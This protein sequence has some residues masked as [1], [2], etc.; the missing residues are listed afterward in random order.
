MGRCTAMRAGP[1]QGGNGGIRNGLKVFGSGEL[2]LKTD[3]LGVRGEF[4]SGFQCFCAF[5][6]RSE[7]L[8]PLVGFTGELSRLRVLAISVTGQFPFICWIFGTCLECETFPFGT[9]VHAMGEDFSV[10]HMCP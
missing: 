5:R 1:A 7:S 10:F 9:R 2:V 6:R 3:V 8:Q 4:R